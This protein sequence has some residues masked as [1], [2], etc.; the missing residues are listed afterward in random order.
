MIPSLSLS[1][2]HLQFVETIGSL[3]NDIHS[4][5]LYLTLRLQLHFLRHT[6][7]SKS[8]K[9]RILNYHNFVEN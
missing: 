8:V 9:P 1:P 4:K 5:I 3:Q 7:Q 6:M 2:F